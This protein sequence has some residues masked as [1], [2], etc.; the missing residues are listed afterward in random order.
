[1]TYF[2]YI[3]RLCNYWCGCFK[4][5]QMCQICN[6]FYF[7]PTGASA[8]KIANT[9]F[10]FLYSSTLPYSNLAFLSHSDWA[11]STATVWYHRL[12]FSLHLAKLASSWASMDDMILVSPANL[13]QW[14]P[15]WSGPTSQKTQNLQ[16]KILPNLKFSHCPKLSHSAWS[17]LFLMFWM[18]LCLCGFFF[19]LQHTSPSRNKDLEPNTLHLKGLGLVHRS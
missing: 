2:F 3:T 13:L 5:L 8:L 4:K 15:W 9:T 19:F 10:L 11:I 17:F 18:L 16:N 14:S 12:A 6:F 7:A 1:M